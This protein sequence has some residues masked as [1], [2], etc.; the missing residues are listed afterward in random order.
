METAHTCQPRAEFENV[1]C[2]NLFVFQIYTTPI[3]A[4]V[5]RFPPQIADGRFCSQTGVTAA[6]SRTL[7]GLE[8][9]HVLKAEVANA[10]EEG[11]QYGLKISF[12]MNT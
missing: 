2:T 4:E 7:T 11:Y 3:C 8:P 6:T 9:W 12:R 10:V 5:P 1:N